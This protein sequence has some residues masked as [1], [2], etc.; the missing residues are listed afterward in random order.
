MSKTSPSLVISMIASLALAAACTDHSGGDVAA[1]QTPEKASHSTET[2]VAEIPAETGG[3]LM[4]QPVDFSTP[5]KA[6]ET[7]QKI[8]EQ[9]GEK[10]YRS[11]NA[12]MNHMLFY[13]LSVNNNKE[14]LYKKLDGQTPKQIVAKKRRK[15]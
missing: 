7:L 4:D 1:E 5:E 9:E 14:L 3:S 11:I 6:E 12:A 2:R 10:V 15:S 8:R 13:D